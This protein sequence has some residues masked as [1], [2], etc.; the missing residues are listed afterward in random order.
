M[1]CLFVCEKLL[2]LLSL[3]IE[4]DRISFFFN[5]YSYG[6]VLLNQKN[7]LLPK[8]NVWPIVERPML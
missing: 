4:M 1:F 6:T 8:V 3:T 2:I 5:Y 7:Y